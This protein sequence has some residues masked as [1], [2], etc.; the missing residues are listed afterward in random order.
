M[1]LP[2]GVPGRYY[3][4]KDIDEQLHH[5][6]AVPSDFTP[7]ALRARQLAFPEHYLGELHGWDGPDKD[8]CKV[9]RDT[10]RIIVRER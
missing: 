3:I 10:G 5:L 7:L 6:L 4:G 9:Y 1:R 8:R 2:L